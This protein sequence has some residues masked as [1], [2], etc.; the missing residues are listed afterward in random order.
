MS[1]N[2]LISKMINEGY[3]LEVCLPLPD[4]KN[5]MISQQVI[6]MRNYE[7][8]ANNHYMFNSTSSFH[9]K[10]SELTLAQFS[11]S[12]LT[13]KLLLPPTEDEEQPPVIGELRMNKL[14]LANNF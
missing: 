7:V 5:E 3:H 13:V 6:V 8:L 4:T 12:A 1:H 2:P 10:V 14:L 11:D 9:F